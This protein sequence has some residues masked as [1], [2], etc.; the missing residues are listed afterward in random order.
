MFDSERLLATPDTPPGHESGIGDLD[1]RSR[2]LVND[3]ELNENYVVYCPDRKS[4]IRLAAA[5]IAQSC[6]VG[7][8]ILYFSDS[9]SM[10]STVA[11]KNEL[12]KYGLESLLLTDLET[13]LDEVLANPT[14]FTD[15]DIKNID[16]ESPKNLL[17]FEEQLKEIFDNIHKAKQ[18]WKISYAKV[19]RRILELETKSQEVLVNVGKDKKE[20][21]E[22]NTR[23]SKDAA[24]NLEG[25]FDKAAELIQKYLQSNQ[26]FNL[27]IHWQDLVIKDEQAVQTVNDILYR[28]VELPPVPTLSQMRSDI[29]AICEELNAPKPQTM[30][31]W[32]SVMDLL[33]DVRQSLD[34][35]NAE[36]FERDLSPF[37]ECFKPREESGLSMFNRYRI[38]K[39]LKSMIRPGLKLSTEELGEKLQAV[40]E[41]QTQWVQKLISADQGSNIPDVIVNRIQV[42]IPIQTSQAYAL[43]NSVRLDLEVLDKMFDDAFEHPLLTDMEFGK[44]TECLEELAI[45]R[46]R[47]YLIPQLQ[48]IENNL[49][50]RGVLELAKEL[51]EIV[52]LD[53]DGK[54]NSDGDIE[55]SESEETREKLEILVEYAWI[56][57]V[58]S[59]IEQNYPQL[60]E[61][62]TWDLD[63]LVKLY[64]ERDLEYIKMLRYPAVFKK[65][66]NLHQILDNYRDELVRF[67]H[68]AQ[69]GALPNI[70][71][72][73][74][75]GY[76]Y[77]VARDLEKQV[78]KNITADTVILDSIE[79]TNFDVVEKILTKGKRFIVLTEKYTEKMIEED[80]PDT[81]FNETA[82]LARL[83]TV[84]ELL[85]QRIPQISEQT[86]VFR[87]QAGD[88]EVK[89]G[90]KDVV[91]FAMSILP[92][93]ELLIVCPDSKTVKELKERLVSAMMRDNEKGHKLAQVFSDLA[94]RNGV[95][96]I[97]RDEE[98]I[99]ES[100][101]QE[102]LEN[103]KNNHIL[104]NWLVTKLR[105]KSPDYEILDDDFGYENILLI[106]NKKN[107][108]KV[109]VL[110]D[111]DYF[112]KVK[113]FR[114]KLRFEPDELK[115]A[116][117]KPVWFWTLGFAKNRAFELAKITDAL[118][119][120][121]SIPSAKERILER[122]GG[123]KPKLDARDKEMI[124]NKPPHWSA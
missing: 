52:D 119:G 51:A 102:T 98:K 57:S 24:I 71:R 123:V 45:V 73:A 88:D 62:S 83:S 50:Y 43:A 82:R 76:T 18:P 100:D 23:L 29:D 17:E 7:E 96:I 89:N 47:L 111:N 79:E 99:I 116:G 64:R 42:K 20:K 4:K 33:I 38:L 66:N 115:T 26:N 113:S 81:K 46:N 1:Q 2:M 108:I 70:F 9:E 106:N 107:N 36:I 34:I 80:N 39:E 112:E 10:N 122:N 16:W 85:P 109:A 21:L 59:Y 22:V 110:F 44:L 105:E 101:S 63:S 124:A 120:A 60:K 92:D 77:S 41:Q 93:Q 94:I 15:D 13:D 27:P 103:I 5:L 118:K 67:E 74:V 86:K 84:Y 75:T 12:R 78:G 49:A 65:I 37:A 69:L 54:T 3:F 56:L 53:G 72:L 11:V 61:F 114:A 48:Q 25:K 87:I 90:A 6:C 40:V 121:D 117:Y 58:K 30:Q 104:M 97:A 95:Q 32:L 8:K 91:S 68:S 35:F 55:E 14:K 19:I 31:E 28:L